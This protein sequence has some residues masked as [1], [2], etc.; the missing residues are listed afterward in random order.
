MEERRGPR[1]GET[2]EGTG[3]RVKL[4]RVQD[5]EK[6]QQSRRTPHEG[7]GVPC[8]YGVETA[9]A[10]SVRKAMFF[11]FALRMAS[12]ATLTAPYLARASAFT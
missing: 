9:R 11:T 1:E 12:R 4:F 5:E 3:V 7:H 10:L 8:P 2:C 6:R